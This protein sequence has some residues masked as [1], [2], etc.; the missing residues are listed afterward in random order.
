MSLGVVGAAASLVEAL[1]IDVD[2]ATTLTNACRRVGKLRC[3]A[4]LKH[5]QVKNTADLLEVKVEHMPFDPVVLPS[6]PPK[7]DTVMHIADV[8][9]ER[10]IDLDMVRTAGCLNNGN[11]DEFPDALKPKVTCAIGRTLSIAIL[12]SE[13]GKYQIVKYFNFDQK[14]A[15][16]LAAKLCENPMNIK[17]A[18]NK[19]KRSQW[20]PLHVRAHGWLPSQILEI[21]RRRLGQG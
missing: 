6:R 7:G 5:A 14:F 3:D 15:L 17:F 13:N 11:W 4:T 8:I 16:H 18:S 1:A 12:P 21:R 19:K 20:F 10:E 9:P 2:K